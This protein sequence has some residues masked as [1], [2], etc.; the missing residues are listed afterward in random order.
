LVF[1]HWPPLE[2]AK[3]AIFWYFLLIFGIFSVAPPGKFSADALGC[4]VPKNSNK[5]DADAKK[6]LL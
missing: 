2:E 4:T 1:F 5:S 6:Y 3:S